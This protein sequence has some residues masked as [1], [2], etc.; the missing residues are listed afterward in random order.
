M[1]ESTDRAAQLDGQVEVTF[2]TKLPQYEA[3]DGAFVVPWGLA[4]Y[5]LSEMLNQLLENEAPVPF[6][7]LVNGEFLREP[8]KLYMKR[9]DLTAETT[10]EI[11]FLLAQAPPEDHKVDINEDWISSVQSTA[12]CVVSASYDGHWRLYKGATL[13]KA[14]TNRDSQHPLKA[15]SLYENGDVLQ[16]ATMSKDGQTSMSSVDASGKVVEEWSGSAMTDGEAVAISLDGEMVAS[17]GCSTVALWNA[18]SSLFGDSK[19]RERREEEAR[20]TI[21]AQ[22]NVLQWQ[23]NALIGGGW[24]AVKVFDVAAAAQIASIPCTAVTAMDTRADTIATAH[25]DG[26]VAVWD[27]RSAYTAQTAIEL[28]VSFL[29]QKRYCAGVA[30]GQQEHLLA[31][32]GHDGALKLL[33]MRSPK[34]ALSQSYVEDA[35]LLCLTWYNASEIVTGASDGQLRIHKFPGMAGAAA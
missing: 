33:D 35:K 4:R 23:E 27:V 29:A 10:L 19:K 6:D 5:G 31:S 12:N 11:E 21:E 25:A 13:S 24:D 14:I 26:R 3:P 17:A 34:Q 15:I 18:G 28:Q 1:A 32:V 16:I 22:A 20:A 30:F 9:K 2:T 8:L 7:F